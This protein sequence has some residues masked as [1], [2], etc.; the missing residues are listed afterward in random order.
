MGQS[1]YATSDYGLYRVYVQNFAVASIIIGLIVV[2]SVFVKSAWCRYVCPYGAVQGLLGIISPVVLVKNQDTCTSCRACN[3][4]CPNAVDVAAVQRSA[5]VSAEC[6]G[7][8]SCVQ[9]C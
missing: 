1:F 7:C 5:V 8:G 6:M 4:A 2:A 3:R 9:A